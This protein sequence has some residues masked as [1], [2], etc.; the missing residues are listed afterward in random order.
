MRQKSGFTFFVVLL[1]VLLVQTGRTQGTDVTPF[2]EQTDEL[3]GA[4]L[5]VENNTLFLE[6]NG[7][8]YSFAV[9]AATQIT[10]GSQPANLE[11]LEARKGQ[12]VT[13]K[14]RVT[15]EG[16]LAQEIAVMGGTNLSWRGRRMMHGMHGMYGM[17][18]TCPMRGGTS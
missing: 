5:M 12:M 16:N 15:R 11:A 3:R 1:A 14:F 17:P 9:S 13:V 8:P 18:E 2:Q 6:R 10:I 7:I 4:I